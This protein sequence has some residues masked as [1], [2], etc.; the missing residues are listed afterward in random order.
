MESEIFRCQTM[1]SGDAES[2]KDTTSAFQK[3]LL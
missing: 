3:F 2:D 1:G